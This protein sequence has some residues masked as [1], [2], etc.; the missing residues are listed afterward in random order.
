MQTVFLFL[1]FAIS[2]NATKTFLTANSGYV[3]IDDQA[4]NDISC[5]LSE[6][7]YQ[8]I[9]VDKN[10]PKIIFVDNFK[11]QSKLE[12]YG[13]TK[14]H[15]IGSAYGASIYAQFVFED[16]YVFP[17]ELKTNAQKA[18]D[19]NL[20]EDC[21]LFKY[22]NQIIVLGEPFAAIKLSGIKSLFGRKV[23]V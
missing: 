21:F 23:V 11:V 22:S 14:G 10:A 13:R 17:K 6:A 3:L 18:D 12:N 9:F 5:L 4:G 16:K 19:S 8:A 2:L 20:P 15:Q 7:D 1:L